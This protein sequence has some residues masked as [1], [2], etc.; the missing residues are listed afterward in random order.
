MDIEED[1]K[2]V[3]GK[4]MA[5]LYIDE[6]FSSLRAGH[7]AILVAAGFS[8]NADTANVQYNAARPREYAGEEPYNLKSLLC[9]T[10]LFFSSWVCNSF[11]I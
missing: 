6:I 11:N 7:T 2:K 8:R 10:V 1:R 9:I 5:E 4:S 3:I